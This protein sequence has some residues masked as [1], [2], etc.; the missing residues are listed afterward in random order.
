MNTNQTIDVVLVPRA[1]AERLAVP[2]LRTPEYLFD[3][4]DALDELRA[5]LD[6]P[7]PF[8]GY[9]PV[10]EDRKLPAAQPP[11]EPVAM[12][13][14]QFEAW[15]LGR[16]HP[17]YGWLDKHWLA[18][19]DNPETYAAPYVQGLWV[20]SQSLYAE[21]PKPVAAPL[22]YGSFD[23]VQRLAVCRG[24]VLP[25]S[26]STC[27]E[28]REEAGQPINRPCKACGGGACIDR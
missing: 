1:L 28:T 19:G 22:D 24:D 14:G 2:M 15:V 4:R 13:R 16:E 25:V 10:P 9:P 12:N 27:N 11:G 7:C 21:Q 6:S 20:A 17:T 8:P 5:L 18:R 3:H 23:A 26:G